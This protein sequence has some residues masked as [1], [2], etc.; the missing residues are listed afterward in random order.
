MESI[1]KLTTMNVSLKYSGLRLCRGVSINYKSI[2][3]LVYYF[4][5]SVWISCL[6]V[7]ATFP[8]RYRRRRYYYYL[9]Q[10]RLMI[11]TECTSVFKYLQI[12]V[13]QSYMKRMQYLFLSNGCLHC[14]VI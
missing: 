14:H 3:E 11:Y 5:N 4:Q 1:F 7:L 10:I 6:T 13:S 2:V 12:S 9:L 8:T